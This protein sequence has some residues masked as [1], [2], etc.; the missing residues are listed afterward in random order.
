ML[1]VVKNQVPEDREEIVGKI[2][3]QKH[4]T[5]KNWNW[6][7]M[8]TRYYLR[9]SASKEDIHTFRMFALGT[10]DSPTKPEG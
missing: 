8:R 10:T 9:Q 3:R 7:W 6:K 1:L 2:F 4:L 5:L